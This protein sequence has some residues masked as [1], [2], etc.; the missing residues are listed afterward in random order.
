LSNAD[1][2]ARE[3]SRYFQSTYRNS[4]GPFDARRK[5]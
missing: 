3:P 5:T 4:K 2:P 1:A